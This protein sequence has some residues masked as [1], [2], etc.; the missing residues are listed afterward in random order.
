MKRIPDVG[1]LST[2][3][4]MV[5]GALPAADPFRAQTAVQAALTVYE[6]AEKQVEAM[7]Q[8]NRL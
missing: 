5:Y 1:Q 4:L 2:L 6:E 8:S 7:E 3:A